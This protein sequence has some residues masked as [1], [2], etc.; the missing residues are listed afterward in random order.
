M[1]P[2]LHSFKQ[3]LLSHS[4]DVE[5]FWTD[6]AEICEI[7]HLKQGESLLRKGQKCNYFYFRESGIMRAFD[8]EDNGNERTRVLFTKQRLFTN[9][10]SYEFDEIS[11]LNIVSINESVIICIRKDQYVKL[12]YKHPEFSML[13]IRLLMMTITRILQRRYKL[14]ILKPYDRYLLL[15]NYIPQVFNDVPQKYLA[16]YLNITT[17]S[18]SRMN[19]RYI[20]ELKENK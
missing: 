8:I 1:N 11:N 13:M 16:S 5:N 3:F 14:D 19:K 15:K 18:L 20:E 7:K 9:Y 4:P 17:V 10:E 12:L 6:I 2:H